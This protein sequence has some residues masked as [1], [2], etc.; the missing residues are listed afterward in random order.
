M[1]AA[2]AAVSMTPGHDENDHAADEISRCCPRLEFCP[3]LGGVLTGQHTLILHTRH[4]IVKE[5]PQKLCGAEDHP[6]HDRHIGQPCGPEQ[7]RQLPPDVALGHSAG[8]R[9]QDDPGRF[10]LRVVEK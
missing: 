3:P 1:R 4:M 2:K 5:S 8:E 7:A 10:G 9:I 6:R